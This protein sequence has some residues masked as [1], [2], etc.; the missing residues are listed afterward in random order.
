MHTLTHT[1]ENEVELALVE[2]KQSAIT[3]QWAQASEWH[4]HQPASVLNPAIPPIAAALLPH[5]GSVSG[6]KVV[7]ACQAAGPAVGCENYT[8][9]RISSRYSQSSNKWIRLLEGNLPV[10]LTVD[11]KLLMVLLT[12]C[13]APRPCPW[14]MVRLWP[15]RN[16]KKELKKLWMLGITVKSCCGLNCI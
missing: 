1:W 9:I 3:D 7:T 8:I 6:P 15:K 16:S 4:W 2:Q 5:L 11:A 14:G 13:L 10:Q 12:L